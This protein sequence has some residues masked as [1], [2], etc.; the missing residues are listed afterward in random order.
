MTGDGVNDAPSLQAADVGI[1]MGLGGSDVAKGASDIVLTDDNFASIVAAIS[2][3]RRLFDNIQRFVL[4]LLT[5]NVAEVV[6]LICGLGFQDST[7]ASVFPLSPLA[8]LFI[9]MLTSS[10]P[11][12]GLGRE[13]ASFD[14]MSRAPR[15]AKKGI[16]TWEIITDMFVYGISM[17]V[18][19]LATFA[20]IVY[21]PEENAATGGYLGHDCNRAYSAGC[22]N[23]FRA[24]AAVFVELTWCIL[25]A[26]WEIKSLRR[27]LFRLNPGAEARFTLFSDLWANQFLFWAVLVG[28]VVVFPVVYIPVLNTSVFKHDAISWEWGVAIGFSIAF[29][30]VMEAWKMVKRTFGW[31]GDG[32]D[33]AERQ[34]RKGLGLK[35][36]FFS[37]SRSF[38]R[39]TTRAKD[40]VQDHEPKDV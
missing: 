34:D 20:L 9:N 23:V 16:F 18:L 3:G 27:S 11:A 4:H 32:N 36:G 38:S 35:Q 6:L 17:G 8:I 25:L 29:L 12:F 24:R 21:Y 1:A 2:E 10:F 33:G 22:Q 15:D 13:K 30:T 7:G 37:F 5:S 19:C 40:A 31:F 14:V 28:A 26:A 39:D